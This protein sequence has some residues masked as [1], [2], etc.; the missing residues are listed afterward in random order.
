M[1]V[2]YQPPQ[3][4]KI[5][6]DSKKILYCGMSLFNIS[7]DLEDIDPALSQICLSIS[8]SL[9]TKLSKIEPP[10]AVIHSV[11]APHNTNVDKEIESLIE[12]IRTTKV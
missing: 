8:K 3:E 12:E 10:Q 6:I 2:E 1:P 9:I 11:N 5:V 7:K 4:E